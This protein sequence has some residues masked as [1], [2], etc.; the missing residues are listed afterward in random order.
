MLKT[1]QP[2]I[3]L[4]QCFVL[5]LHVDPLGLTI[6]L[7]QYF[8][9]SVFKRGCATWCGCCKWGTRSSSTMAWSFTIQ[10]QEMF[11]LKVNL[12]LHQDRNIASARI[13]WSHWLSWPCFL[14]GI[15]SDT[16]LLT[17]MYIGEM[18]FWAVKYEDCS[19]DSTERKE[20]SLQ[21]RDIGTQILN[22][23]VLACEGPLQGQGWNT[24]NAK[25]ILSILQWIKLF[26]C[27]PQA[28]IWRQYLIMSSPKK[29]KKKNGAQ[30]AGRRYCRYEC[31]MTGGG[32]VRETYEGI[33]ACWR[34]HPM[35]NSPGQSQGKRG[36]EVGKEKMKTTTDCGWKA[37]CRVIFL[38]LLIKQFHPD[39][40]LLTGAL[41][42]L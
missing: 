4:D 33:S 28:Q 34:P 1:F 15:F 42:L 8:I 30:Q 37:G 9:H 38:N 13:I 25:E 27:R 39:S 6:L 7:T 21:F 26:L 29:K 11:F 22:K 35:P 41:I 18:C 36:K 40:R 31:R 2:F 5:L 19:A 23:Y 24:E 10:Q 32:T 20:D 17:M 14:S 12:E 3:I 16:H